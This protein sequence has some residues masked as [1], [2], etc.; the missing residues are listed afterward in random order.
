MEKDR[1]IFSFKDL[2]MPEFNKPKITNE[3]QLVIKEFVDEINK[4]RNNTKWKPIT[5]R[6]VAIK[7]SHI[8]SLSDLYYFLSV[9]RDYAHRNGSFSKCFFG[10]LKPLQKN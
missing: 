6:A 2:K 5:A 9:C 10:S 3:R 8:K 7:L 1:E 4:E